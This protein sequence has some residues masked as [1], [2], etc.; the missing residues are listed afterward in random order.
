[1]Q[2]D[3]RIAATGVVLELDKSQQVVKKLKLT[4]T[5]QKIYNKT[6]FIQV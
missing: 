6:A 4:G 5:P 3:F 2:A 1:L